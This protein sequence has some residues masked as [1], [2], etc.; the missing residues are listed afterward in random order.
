MYLLDMWGTISLS[1]LCLR[2]DLNEGEGAR[3]STAVDG[4]PES[5][6]TTCGASCW[7]RQIVNILVSKHRS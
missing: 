7:K 5:T 6:E 2:L 3:R 4:G 1:L